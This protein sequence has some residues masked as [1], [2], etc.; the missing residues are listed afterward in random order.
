LSSDFKA[1]D[2]SKESFAMIEKQIR[3]PNN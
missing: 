1:Y 2:G 3:I